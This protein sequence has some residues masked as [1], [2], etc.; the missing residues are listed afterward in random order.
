MRQEL[1]RRVKDIL[2]EGD[3][4]KVR[5]DSAALQLSGVSSSLTTGCEP[6]EQHRGSLA[7]SHLRP[8]SLLASSVAG[9]VD[10][11]ASLVSDK[12][13]AYRARLSDLVDS[14]SDS[15]DL[16]SQSIV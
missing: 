12:M 5:L 15:L 6:L 2:F 13:V 11:M 1:D 14:A 10:K 7:A 16:D 8:K 3:G 9:F 4:L